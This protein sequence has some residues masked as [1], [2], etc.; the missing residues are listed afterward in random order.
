[1]AKSKKT[2]PSKARRVPAT[3]MPTQAAV[4]VP[5]TYGE[6]KYL[7]TAIF[8]ILGIAI[9]RLFIFSDLDSAQFEVFLR[10]QA[11][12]SFG[13]LMQSAA[14]WK[15]ALGFA[16][17]ATGGYFL[18]RDI[19]EN[20]Q[21]DILSRRAAIFL[22]VLIVYIPA[23]SAGYIWDDDQLVT[24]N[25]SLRTLGGLGEIWA[26]TKSADYFPLT[27]TLFW[28][29]NHFW[30]LWSP[31]YHTVN[32]LF[33]AVDTILLGCVLVKL[34]IPG[35]W[36]AAL[37]FGVHPVH[38]ESV[39]WIAEGKNTVSLFFYLL[40]LLCYFKFERTERWQDYIWALV[41]FLAALLSKTHMVVLPMVL[42]LCAWW[43]QKFNGLRNDP[44]SNPSERWLIKATNMVVGVIGI[45]AGIAGAI[46]LLWLTHR[47]HQNPNDEAILAMH[48]FKNDAIPTEF[49]LLCAICVGSGVVGLT[50]GV[51]GQRFSRHL[52]RSLAFFQLAVLFGVVTVWFQYGRAI[53]AEEIPIGNFW[54][55]LANAGMAVWWYL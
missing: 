39:S 14:F 18:V 16:V 55:R 28:I 49:W 48:L 31:G 46:G 33:H 13:G 29:E 2:A 40:T 8:G 21:L 38:A 37:I 41:C 25:P 51:F 3:A 45:V 50:E 35:A 9:A 26:G 44:I 52:V 43:R 54:S 47:Y 10:G 1:M 11:A 23:M 5:K 32:I 12:F 6:T 4:P 7:L 42:L 53:G 34:R 27:L 20:P 36:L 24:A 19:P 22:A 15:A 30:G 17:A